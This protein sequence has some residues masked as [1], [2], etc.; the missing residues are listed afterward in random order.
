MTET[1]LAGKN[2]NIAL[3]HY[4]VYDK[5]R[6]IVTT[7]VTNLD[8]HD[9]ARAA[10]TFGLNR[11]YVVTPFEDQKELASRIVQHWQNGWGASYNTKRKEALDL[12]SVVDCL[13]DAVKDLTRENDRPVR[14]V[15]T[16]AKRN[17][18]NIS[19][20]EMAELLEDGDYQYLILLGTGWG[21]TEE[22]LSGADY[23]LEPI[24]GS[25]TYNHLSVRSA[26][27]II[28]DRLLGRK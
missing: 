9:I 4:P 1:R 27:A 19:Y 14:I 15:A 17:G 3:L 10:K 26:A 8:L 6:S 25:G 24:K 11:Y 22:V 16:C 13:A 20:P 21:L 7:A 18:S 12:I 28:M 23:I 2:V 5:N